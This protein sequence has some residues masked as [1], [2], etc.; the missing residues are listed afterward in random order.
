M[1]LI[2]D[3]YDRETEELLF[4]GDYEEVKSK[5]NISSSSLSNIVN[6]FNST[7]YPYIIKINNVEENAEEIISCIKRH[8]DTYGNTI[9]NRSQ[10]KHLKALIDK[11]Y[12]IKTKPS[13]YDRN[14]LIVEL[15]KNG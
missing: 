9:I 14:F 15:E 5:I 2:Y 4:T 7:K 6:G 3:V 11:G 12:K 1:R 13:I 10:S 8:L